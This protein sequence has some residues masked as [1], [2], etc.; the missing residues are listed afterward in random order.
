MLDVF[1][2]TRAL[3]AGERRLRT[4]CR[5]EVGLIIVQRA[6]YWKQR[7]KFRALKEGD[8]NT[9][10]IHAR[11]SCRARRNAIR[12]LQVDDTTLVTHD[13]KVTALT[14]YYSTILGGEAATT[15]EF[16]ID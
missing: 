5:E 6:A 2:E 4:L 10:Y 9:K 12:A 13:D 7:G 3:S 8:A 14:A 1:E 11:A 16:D 15:W